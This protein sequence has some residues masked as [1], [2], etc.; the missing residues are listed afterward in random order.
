M[1]KAE[2]DRKR[3]REFLDLVENE[4]YDL[5]KYSRPVLVFCVDENKKVKYSLWESDLLDRF[6]LSNVD[7]WDYEEDISFCP[8][9]VDDYDD[10]DWDEDD[11]D[12]F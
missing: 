8:D 11:D 7:G 2:K 6:G 9:W 4:K 3:I 5:R 1:M 10:D 12:D